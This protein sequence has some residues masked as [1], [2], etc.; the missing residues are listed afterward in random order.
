MTNPT[1]VAAGTSRAR[2]HGRHERHDSDRGQDA[3]GGGPLFQAMARRLRAA[4]VVAH[5][6]TLSGGQTFP[7]A[8]SR[9]ARPRDPQRR[10][11]GKGLIV[12][13]AAAA[14]VL[15]IVAI[16]IAARGMRPK[17]DVQLTDRS[18]RRPP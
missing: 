9:P 5:A 3:V 16:V 8:P 7:T 6:D 13:L 15:G 1:P 4:A 11:G 10:A 17:D 18:A 12:G 2:C 14:G